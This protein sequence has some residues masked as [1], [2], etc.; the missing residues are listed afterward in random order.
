MYRKLQLKSSVWH[1]QDLEFEWDPAARSVRGRDAQLVLEAVAD[2]VKAGEVVSH[3]IPTTY[4]I[5]NP[6]Q[7]A[8]EMAAVLGQYWQLPQD[9]ADELALEADEDEPAMLEDEHGQLKPIQILH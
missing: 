8:R 3:P 1:K 4:Q 5:T 2:A 6:L 7:H 9:L